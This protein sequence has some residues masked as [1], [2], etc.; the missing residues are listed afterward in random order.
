MVYGYLDV[1]FMHIL[2][3]FF[4]YSSPCFVYVCV[5]YTYVLLNVHYLIFVLIYNV[6]KKKILGIGFNIPAL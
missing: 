3:C 4:L 2:H 5:F 6:K 1:C